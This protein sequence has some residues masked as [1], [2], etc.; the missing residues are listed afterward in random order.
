MKIKPKVGDKLFVVGAGF[1]FEAAVSAVKNKTFTV[2]MNAAPDWSSL[3]PWENKF[4]FG[5][6]EGYE[7]DNEYA[8]FWSVEEWQRQ[9]RQIDLE[10]AIRQRFCWR[11]DLTQEEL[12]RIYRSLTGKDYVR[13]EW[14]SVW[15]EKY[16]KGIVK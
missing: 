11:K 9:Q 5:C 4:K 8:V 10:I 13:E 3:G 1:I 14:Q 6:E 15:E 12:L 7:N 2:K 16:L